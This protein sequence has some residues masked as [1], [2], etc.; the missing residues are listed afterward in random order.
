[1]RGE[2]VETASHLRV[3][4]GPGVLEQRRVDVAEAHLTG[5][6]AD[7]LMTSL[8]GGDKTV[9]HPEPFVGHQRMSRRR[10]HR[11]GSP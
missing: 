9:D 5:Q 10:S 4:L 6:V 3:D 2:F 1:M 11:P 7:L 8:R